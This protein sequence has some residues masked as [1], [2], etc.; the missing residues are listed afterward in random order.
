MLNT[1]GAATN[2]TEVCERASGRRRYHSVRRLQVLLRRRKVAR[3]LAREGLGYGVRARL[4]R[5][6]KVSKATITADVR[7]IL[8]TSLVSPGSA[9][10]RSDAQRPRGHGVGGYRLRR[11]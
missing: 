6:F 10:E 1:W 5:Q 2:W 3:C 7:A 8:A 4:A 11:R 9:I